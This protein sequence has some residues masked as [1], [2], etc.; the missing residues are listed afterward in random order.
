LP[1][2]ALASPCIHDAEVA[3]LMQTQLTVL[4]GASSPIIRMMQ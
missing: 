4:A 2:P 3:S 1:N